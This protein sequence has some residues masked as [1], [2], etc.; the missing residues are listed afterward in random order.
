[1][2]FQPQ[3]NSQVQ[4]SCSEGS[5][6]VLE[7]LDVQKSEVDVLSHPSEVLVALR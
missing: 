5:V 7:G 6:F 1:M 4:K 2:Y 3:Q